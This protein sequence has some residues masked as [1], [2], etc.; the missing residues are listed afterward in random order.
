MSFSKAVFLFF[1]LCCITLTVSAQRELQYSILSSGSLIYQYQEIENT[2]FALNYTEKQTDIGF[3]LN[4]PS[5]LVNNEKGN[6]HEFGISQ[7]FIQDEDRPIYYEENGV[8]QVTGTRML[9]SGIGFVYA[10]SV[11]LF[12]NNDHATKFFI[13]PTLELNFNYMNSRPYASNAFAVTTSNISLNIAAMPRLQSDLNEHWFVD[14]SIPVSLGFLNLEEITVQNPNFSA[15]EQKTG[16]F[17]LEYFRNRVEFRIGVG[18][19]LAKHT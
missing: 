18:Y 2:D 12:K 7:L 19:R 13:G 11:K 10:Y 8:K 5:L 17:D 16:S 4:W 6:I 3:H 14:F 15:N 9:K 1:T